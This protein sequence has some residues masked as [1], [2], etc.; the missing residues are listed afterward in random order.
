VPVLCCA[1]LCCAVLCCAVLC[2]AVLCRAVPC[3]AVLC[4]AVL[5]HRGA[6]GRGTFSSQNAALAPGQFA[7]SPPAVR[8]SYCG[9]VQ[10]PYKEKRGRDYLIDADGNKIQLPR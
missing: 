5:P 2:C 4:C 6:G 3:R 7:L 9:K 1:V 10:K 8:C